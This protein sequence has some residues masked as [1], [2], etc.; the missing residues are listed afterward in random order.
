[1]V[2]SLALKGFF[3]PSSVVV[4]GA[5]RTPGKI[6]YEILRVLVENKRSG[7]FRGNLYAVNPRSDEMILGVPTYKSVMEVPEPPELAVIVTPASQTPQALEECGEKGVRNAVVI[8]GGFAEVGGEGLILQRRLDEIRR[9]YGIRIVG[10]NCVGVIS[11]STGVD[12]LFLPVEKELRGN[13]YISSPRPKP[14]SVALS[15][16][17]GAFGVACLDY[18]YGEGIGLSKFIS[19]GNKIDV[20]E[21]DAISYL[22]DDPETKVILIYAESIDRGREFLELAR[23]VT[24]E[25][26][27]V[28]LKAGRTSAGAKAASSHTAA[29]AGSDAIYDAAFKQAGVI[30]VWDMEE[31][32]DVAKALAMQPPAEGESVAILTDG[33]GVGVMAADEVEASGLKLA[34]FSPLTMEKLRELQKSDVIPPIASLS[35]PIDLTGSATDDSFIGALELILQDPNVFGVIVLALHHVPGVT[36][37]LPRRIADVSRGYRK[38][39]VAMDVGSSRYAVEFRKLFEIEGIPAYPEPERAVKAMRALVQY[40]IARRSLRDRSS[41]LPPLVREARW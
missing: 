14:G 39:V 2:I 38:P 8:S 22:K 11:P 3:E 13:I 16:Q 21:V 20:D 23:E 41:S 36:S 31:L 5:S 12:T 40:G 1:M 29:I 33:G 37:E 35:N 34:E 6:G 10:P 9:K 7:T 18:M 4:V 25:K 28:V 24:K 17:S 19:Y 32:F 26:P 27:I 15:T 30:R